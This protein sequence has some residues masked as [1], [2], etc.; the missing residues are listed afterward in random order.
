[1]EKAQFHQRRTLTHKI[2]EG[3]KEPDIGRFE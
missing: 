2:M 3:D 1:M